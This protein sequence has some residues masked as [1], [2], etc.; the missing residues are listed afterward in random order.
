MLLAGTAKIFTP[1]ATTFAGRLANHATLQLLA[2]QRIASSNLFKL[3][4]VFSKTWCMRQK[5]NMISITLIY[6]QLLFKDNYSKS[7]V[8]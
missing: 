6:R 5:P 4:L 2:W 1:T 3:L 7:C 8:S